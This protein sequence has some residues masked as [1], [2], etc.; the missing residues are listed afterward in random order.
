[1]PRS[2]VKTTFICDSCGNESPK[3]EG[4]C[5]SCGEW[6]AMVEVRRDERGTGDGHWAGVPAL[7]TQELSQVSAEPVPRMQL[8]SAE[9]NRVL[10][11]G[12]VP[13]SVV[14]IAGDPGIGKSTLLL[15]IAG[16]VASEVGQVLYVTGEESISRFG[17]EPV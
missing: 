17:S 2:K 1:M 6:N 15:R 7:P 3:W 13:G 16:D 10:G 5:P 12:I 4:R 8:S 14:A 11:G 9:V